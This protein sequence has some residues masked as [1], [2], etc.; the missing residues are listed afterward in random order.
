MEPGTTRKRVGKGAQANTLV[1]VF[2]MS[3]SLAAFRGVTL[4]PRTV[5]PV[6]FIANL[7]VDR[8]RAAYS[9]NEQVIGDPLDGVVVPEGVYPAQGHKVRVLVANNG[10]EG[11]F[12]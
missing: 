5:T 11:K 4:P 10:S 8:H 1:L 7:S 6:D 9:L 3:L 12:L 2:D